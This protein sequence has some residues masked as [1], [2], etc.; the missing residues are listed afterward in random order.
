MWN[1]D[2]SGAAGRLEKKVRIDDKEEY[3]N[4]NY[5]DLQSL[6]NSTAYQ[7]VFNSDWVGILIYVD[8]QTDYAE[9]DLQLQMDAENDH[10]ALPLRCGVW[11][12]MAVKRIYRADTTSNLRIYLGGFRA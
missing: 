12:R 8:A 3:T 7:S 11:H 4:G 2:G 10:A 9:I 5:I 1:F 6:K